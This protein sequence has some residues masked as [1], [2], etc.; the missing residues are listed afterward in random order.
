MELKSFSEEF[1][2]VKIAKGVYFEDSRGSLKKTMFGDELNELMDSIKE[3]IC[4]TSNKDV[5]KIGIKKI[6]MW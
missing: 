5:V 4:S 2:D 6:R 3:V 1:T